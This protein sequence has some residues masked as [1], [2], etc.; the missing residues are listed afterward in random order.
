MNA[1]LKWKT[2]EERYPKLKPEIYEL[3]HNT[4]PGG[5]PKLKPEIYELIHNTFPG[6]LYEITKDEGV[7]L[8]Q[9]SIGIQKRELKRLLE[10]EGENEIQ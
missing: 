5:L 6:S 4:S 7:G 10:L 8:L 2:L 1:D 3:I 9:N